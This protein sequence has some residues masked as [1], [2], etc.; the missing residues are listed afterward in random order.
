MKP[1][2]DYIFIEELSNEVVEKA[3]KLGLY[4][5]DVETDADTCAKGVITAVGPDVA[6]VSVG[7]N[8]A[9]NINQY[10]SLFYEKRESGGKKKTLVGK[11]AGIYAVCEKL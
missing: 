6:Q 5:G 1:V 9:F 11:L 2:G 8:V 10:D 3:E 4:I 7:Q